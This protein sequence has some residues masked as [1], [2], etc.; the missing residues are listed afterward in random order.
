MVSMAARKPVRSVLQCAGG[1]N[2]GRILTCP[3]RVGSAASSCCGDAFSLLRRA[4]TDSGASSKP[5]RTN[6][7]CFVSFQS[8]RTSG[9]MD[10]TPCPSHHP[11]GQVLPFPAWHLFPWPAQD[12]PRGGGTMSG[13]PSLPCAQWT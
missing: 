9:H 4:S 7:P 2:E 10:E 11:R 3:Q 5:V 6:H 1:L 8:G 13:G 12:T